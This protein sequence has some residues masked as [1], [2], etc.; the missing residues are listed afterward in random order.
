M[1]N[2]KWGLVTP[3][4]TV[5][6]LPSGREGESPARSYKRFAFSGVARAQTMLVAYAGPVARMEARWLYLTNCR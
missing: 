6:V 1:E 3:G 5:K 2:E 4:F